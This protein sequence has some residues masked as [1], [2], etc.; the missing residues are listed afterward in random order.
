MTEKLTVPAPIVK[1]KWSKK[2]DADLTEAVETIGG[3]SWSRI[4]EAVPGRSG[5]QCRDRWMNQLNP[6]LNHREWTRD[7]DE[8]LICQQ[9]MFGNCWARIA[10]SLPQRA[11]N[12]VK[13]RW[14]WISRN[15]QLMQRERQEMPRMYGVELCVP[16]C[17]TRMVPMIVA[18]ARDWVR[19]EDQNGQAIG[20]WNGKRL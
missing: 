20:V 16:V 3:N 14:T 10:K 9:R 13:N 18:T 6:E 2:E 1:L 8:L 17:Q 4:A 15:W 5:K 12:A 7:E 19:V 11:S